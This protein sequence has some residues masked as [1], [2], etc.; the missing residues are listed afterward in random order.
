MGG[1]VLVVVVIGGGS[2]VVLLLPA[3]V[4]VVALVV[5]LLLLV[6][7]PFLL[8][9][10]SL[11]IHAHEVLA[12]VQ[13]MGASVGWTSPRIAPAQRRSLTVLAPHRFVRAKEIAGQH[14]RE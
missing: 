1:V 14:S 5:V 9:A 2:I 11:F 6:L 13:H 4:A 3:L 7:L 8:L 10:P 12:T